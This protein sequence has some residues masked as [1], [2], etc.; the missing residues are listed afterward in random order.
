[1]PMDLLKR[2]ALV[3][4]AALGLLAGSVGGEEEL[5]VAN[6]S[7]QVK[8]YPHKYQAPA[9]SSRG[10]ELRGVRNGRFAGQLLAS[11]FVPMEGIKATASAL[12]GAGTIPAT[13]ITIRWGVLD[14]ALSGRKG[15]PSIDSLEDDP[16]EEVSVT[17]DAAV[18]PIWLTVDIPA[19]AKPGEYTGKVTVSAKDHQTVTVPLKL[20][21]VDWV[22]P[23]PN[24]FAGHMDIVQ[25]PESV[26][27]A[28]G[29]ELWSDEHI[30]LLDRTFRHLR[31]LADKTLYISAIR[32]TH[33]GN[34]HAI[35]RWVRDDKGELLPDFTN[36]EKYLDVA[37][38]HLGKIPAVILLCW[39]PESSM[40]HAGGSGGAGR[41]HDKPILYTLWDKK[42]NKLRKR[43]GPAWG[44]PEAKVFWKKFTDGMRP[45]LKKRGLE[46]SM[47]FGLVGDARPTKIAMDDITNGVE[48]A[49]WAIH[50]HH[51]AANWQGYDFGMCVALWGIHLN[52]V[53][54]K[55]GLM[56][57]YGWQ[58]PNWLAYYP[59]EFALTS[60]LPEHRYKLEMW[61]GAF[62]L[63]EAKH[64]GKSRTARG[65][66]RIGGDF[67]KVVKDHRGR[68]RATLAGYYP[69][70]YWGQLNLNYCIPYILG[71]GKKG[72]VPTARS[73]A[74]REGLQEAEARVFIEK[75]IVLKDRRAKVGE[76]YAK[77]ARKFLDDRIRMVN[78]SGGTRKDSAGTARAAL[79][80]G[81]WEKSGET[82]F[83]LAAEAAKKLGN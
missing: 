79:A 48:K 3:S 38:K 52:I 75:A 4:A 69:E 39:E 67:W 60:P 31:L 14:G 70:S 26:A 34:E 29:V 30:K 43:T 68:I 82:L 49:R 58:N 51:Y 15:T 20:R 41:T 59:R 18:Q 33:F 9:A 63:F 22:L 23:N 80:Q 50:S 44:T 19:D 74:F 54:P 62:S 27:L 13:A 25:S 2:F 65:L 76:E 57:G 47:M 73:E 42:R 1:M 45:I 16:P 12:S 28:Y 61:M 37:V 77:R 24:D 8:V 10:L 81:G 64:K 83:L 6:H 71:K 46:K 5:F 78:R 17:N 53:D 72:A 56:Y 11:S 21:V 32:R 40:G 7:I 35:V 66:G 55:P 36:T